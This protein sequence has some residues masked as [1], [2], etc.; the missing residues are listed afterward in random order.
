MVA[1]S[2]TTLEEAASELAG[3]VTGR[4]TPNRPLAPLTTFRV[5]GPA[6]IFVE[7]ANETDLEITGRIAYG[8]SIPVWI[9]GKGSNVLVADAG[10]PGIVIRMA[11]GFDWIRQ[12][13]SSDRVE[14]GGAATLP[15]VSNWAAKRALTG[16]EF[17]VAIPATVGGGV[18]MN[19]GAHGS[20]VSMV[21]E[22]VRICFLAEGRTE[23]AQATELDMTYRRTRLGPD[24]VV[25]SANF[26]LQPGDPVEI[27][28]KMREHRRHRSTTQPSEAPNAGSMFKNPPGGSA[29]ELIES[30]GLKGTSVGRAEVSAKHGNFFLARPGATAQNVYDLMAAVQAAVEERLGVRLIPEVKLIGRFDEAAG[31]KTA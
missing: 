11:K 5:G 9:M 26:L 14:A 21:L 13:S 17:A 12:G 28:A 16:L 1:P 3:S 20:D 7:P 6:A 8:R 10:F 18:A 24:S 30:A 23:S 27:A 19:A 2:A 15:Q 31:L 4:V 22:S 25:C 29:G